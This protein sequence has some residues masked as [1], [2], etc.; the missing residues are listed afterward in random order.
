MREK[1]NRPVYVKHKLSNVLNVSK[2]VTIHYFEYEKNYFYPGESHDFWEMIYVDSGSV[3][4]TSDKNRYTLCQ[5]EVIFHRPNAFHTISTD[6]NTRANV[7]A[8]SF[9]ST[10]VNMNYFRDKKILLPEKLRGYIKILLAEGKNSFDVS[11]NNHGLRELTV[12][13]DPAFGGQQM[14]RTTLEQLLISI[15]RVQISNS[16]GMYV[17]EDKE[18]IDNNLIHS[19]VDLLSD[20]IYGRITVEE[21]CRELNYSKTYISKIFSKYCGC[22][23]IE[24]YTKLKINEAKRLIREGEKSIADVSAKLYF[25]DAHYFSRV[26][27]KTTNMT[28]REYLKSV[29]K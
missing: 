9:V 21:I 20:N 14:I 23:I 22:T 29:S 15:I 3:M 7:F 25:N 18:S 5:G 16:E 2:I 1:I 19:V 12:L 10:S 27:K 13:E 4:I 6:G 24:Y 17:A 28:P 8:I 11:V 26:F